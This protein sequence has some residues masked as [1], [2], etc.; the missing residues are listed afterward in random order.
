M[1]PIPLQNATATPAGVPPS[2]AESTAPAACAALLRPDEVDNPY[3]FDKAPT[4]QDVRYSD[5]PQRLLYPSWKPEPSYASRLS[6]A[7]LSKALSQYDGRANGSQPCDDVFVLRVLSELAYIAAMFPKPG[8]PRMTGFFD[9]D[10]LRRLSCWTAGDPS[11]TQDARLRRRVIVVQYVRL[12][13][14]LVGTKE[15]EPGP[16]LDGLSRADGSSEPPMLM[17]LASAAASDT[18]VAVAMC[19][20]LSSLLHVR[21]DRPQFL[22]DLALQLLTTRDARGLKAGDKYDTFFGRVFGDGTEAGRS[23]AHIVAYRLNRMEILPTDAQVT[24]VH[25][26][27]RAAKWRLTRERGEDWGRGSVQGVAGEWR[28]EEQAARL[29]QR[30]HIDAHWLVADS[31]SFTTSVPLPATGPSSAPLRPVAALFRSLRGDPRRSGPQASAGPAA[32][33]VTRST[34]ASPTS[35]AA[36]ASVPA[37]GARR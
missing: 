21:C 37:S 19:D 29:L 25:S 27:E 35:A 13:A 10:V 32:R 33:P 8:I 17:S 4:F 18:N 28:V 7:Y 14:A 1:H 24:K 23:G 26:A 30:T 3:G 12:L 11:L 5:P 22:K 34:A 16:L 20:L 36:S 15:L 31:R 6:S 2:Y 9:K